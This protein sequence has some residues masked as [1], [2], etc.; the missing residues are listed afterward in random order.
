M[1]RDNLNGFIVVDVNEFTR[2]RVSVNG[3]FQ[4]G[5]P[6]CGAPTGCIWAIAICIWC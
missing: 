1:P 5:A 4:T 6:I 2:I 3:K